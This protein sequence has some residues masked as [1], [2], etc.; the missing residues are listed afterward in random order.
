MAKMDIALDLG[1]SYTSIYVSGYGIVL[2]EP[3]VV[4]FYDKAPRRVRAVG[5]D[6]YQMIGKA[7]DK[8]KIVRP[9]TG[10]IIKD[11]E[12]CT[13]M[14][15]EFLKKIL[16]QSYV[17]KPKIRA[18]VGV[19][20]GITV[21]E[22]KMYEETLMGAG[23]D[24]IEMINSVMLAAVGT[25]NPVRS[26]YGGFIVSIGGGATEI[27]VIS[28]CGIVTGCS[29]SIGGD[30]ID[31][32]LADSIQ[33]I[34]DIKV[35][36][37]TVRRIKERIASLIRNDCATM[38]VNG[39]NNLTNTIT[40]V[41]VSGDRLYRSVATYYESIIK[42]VYKVIKSCS[43]ALAAAIRENGITVV[44]G[45]ANIPG[46]DILMSERLGLRVTIPHDA[47][48]AVIAGAGM[49]LTDPDYLYDVIRHS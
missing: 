11:A 19:P 44:G 3:S 33:G 42:S 31:R 34:H 2:H 18:V 46:L 4:A 21:E 32:A 26:D 1:T 9:I 28:L 41:E 17:F 25:D 30:M 43:P 24:E 39:L 35:D 7:S 13:A 27:A 37:V 8:I 36:S 45:A 16:P 12:A 29:I 47:Q 40:S 23:I 49:L 38:T 22:R 48:Y 15:S 10:G 6:A 5:D 14:L 20:T